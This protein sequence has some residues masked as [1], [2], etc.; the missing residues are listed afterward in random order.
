MRSILNISTVFII[1]ILIITSSCSKTNT[2][3]SEVLD[4]ILSKGVIRVGT[5]FLGTPFAYYQDNVPT[6]FEVELVEAIAKELNVKVEWIKT[7]FDPENFVKLLTNNEIDIIIESISRTVERKNKLNFSQS[8]FTS[9][10]AVVISKNENVP[11]RFDLSLLK[12]KKVG[13]EKGTTG[14]IFAKNNTSGEIIEFQN[15]EDLI[16]ALLKGDVYAI[17]ND[18]FSTQTTGWPLWKELKVVLKNLTHEE[19]CIS[20]K[21]DEDEFLNRLNEILNKFKDDPIEGTYAK[22]YRKWFY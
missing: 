17:I 8:Y 21:K 16:N 5:D 3:N 22:L 11:D 4:R 20:I 10:Q 6:G 12:G 15:S 13:V 19:Y 1:I 18:I 7:N 9:G 14:A 2:K